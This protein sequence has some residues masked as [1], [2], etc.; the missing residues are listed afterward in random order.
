MPRI[1]RYPR[2]RLCRRTNPARLFLWLR[3][4]FGKGR[5]LPH[6]RRFVESRPI[7]HGAEASSAN[8]GS[9]VYFVVRSCVR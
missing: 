3:G 5:S 4:Q 8:L 2:C 1:Y 6:Y 9:V 7:F